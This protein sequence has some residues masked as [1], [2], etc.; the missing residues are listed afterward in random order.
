M[1]QQ[2]LDNLNELSETIRKD[3]TRIASIDSII[4]LVPQRIT[5]WADISNTQSFSIEEVEPEFRSLLQLL[6]SR[7]SER[8]AQ[9]EKTF[10]NMQI[11]PQD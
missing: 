1:T 5:V 9:M 8:L 4:N 11:N 3:K 2:E 7:L 6:I 10:D